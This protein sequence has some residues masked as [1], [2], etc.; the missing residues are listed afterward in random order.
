VRV[1]TGLGVA[2]IFIREPEQL[3][4]QSSMPVSGLDPG[5]VAGIH[6]FSCKLSARKTWI[7]GTSPAMTPREWFHMTARRDAGT[8][9]LPE[10]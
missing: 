3:A 9:H 8:F 4:S 7:A 6:V 10:L 2:K 5:I 1:R